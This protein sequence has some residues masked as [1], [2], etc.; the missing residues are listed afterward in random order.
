MTT[1]Y[2]R[3]LSLL[4]TSAAFAL[5]EKAAAGSRTSSKSTLCQGGNNKKGNDDDDDGWSAALDAFAKQTGE[6][7][8]Y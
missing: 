8:R 1:R 7:V 3:A 4:G 5:V 6:K 2:Y